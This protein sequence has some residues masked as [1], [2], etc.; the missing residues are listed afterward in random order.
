MNFFTGSSDCENVIVV[1]PKCN[2]S[3]DQVT[4]YTRLAILDCKQRGESALSNQMLVMCSIPWSDNDNMSYDEGDD[5]PTPFHAGRIWCINSVLVGWSKAASKV[6]FYLDQGIDQDM[7]DIYRFFRSSDRPDLKIEF[8]RW[9][10]SNGELRLVCERARDTGSRI[11][12]AT[13]VAQ[14][15]SEFL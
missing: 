1:T 9:D 4:Q 8:R 3:S 12:L 2:A 5:R 7:L 6:V 13:S 10:K 15:P 14:I 11:P